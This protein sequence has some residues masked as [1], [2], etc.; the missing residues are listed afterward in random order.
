VYDT[1]GARL[2]KVKTVLN[3]GAADLLEIALTGTPETVLLP[4][5]KVSVPTVDLSAGRLIADPPEG[6]M[7]EE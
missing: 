3:H 4:F 2:G 7:P 6:L 1:G 5:T